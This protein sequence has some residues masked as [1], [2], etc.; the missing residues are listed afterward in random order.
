MATDYC[1]SKL[2][3]GIMPKLKLTIITAIMLIFSIINGIQISRI[4]SKSFFAGF[5]VTFVFCMIIFLLQSIYFIVTIKKLAK[6]NNLLIDDYQSPLD[7]WLIAIPFCALMLITYL[8]LKWNVT[9]IYICT[10]FALIGMLLGNALGRGSKKWSLSKSMPF[11]I[12]IVA[13][14]LFAMIMEWMI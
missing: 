4:G 3:E 11:F 13:S 5:I 12:G 2:K 14:T 1:H 8:F 9:Q 6:D 7:I 10:T